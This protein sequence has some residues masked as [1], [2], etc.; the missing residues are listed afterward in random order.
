[1]KAKRMMTLSAIVLSVAGFYNCVSREEDDYLSKQQQIPATIIIEEAQ[2]NTTEMRKPTLDEFRGAFEDG[3]RWLQSKAADTSFLAYKILILD[4]YPMLQELKQ[5]HP[6][7]S[8]IGKYEEELVRIINDNYENAI[9]SGGKYLNTLRQRG[10]SVEVSNVEE[11][12]KAIKLEYSSK[13]M[14]NR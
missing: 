1:M 12:I 9:L 2:S 8:E 10:D 13:F 5:Q 4:A 7:N 3:T 11:L 14:Q 6:Q